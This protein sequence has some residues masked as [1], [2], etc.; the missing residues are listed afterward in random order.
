MIAKVSMI[1]SLINE[2]DAISQIGGRINL[3]RASQE[4]SQHKREALDRGKNK[5]DLNNVS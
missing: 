5:I 3:T 4:R 2:M 1:K